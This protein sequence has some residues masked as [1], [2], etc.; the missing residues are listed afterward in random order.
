VPVLVTLLDT[1]DPQIR[2]GLGQVAALLEREQTVQALRSV[3]RSR[4][5][6]DNARLTAM[7]ILDRYLHEPVDESLLAGLQDPEAVASQSLRELSHE[8][9]NNPFIVLEYLNQLG[10]QPAEVAGVVLDAIPRLRPDPHLV[11][12]LRMFAQGGDTALAQRALD[13][14]SRIRAPEAGRALLSLTGALPSSLAA[15]ADRGLR[16]LRLLGIAEQAPAG[17]KQW[18]AFLSP[19]DGTGAQ[20]IWFTSHAGD[21][22]HGTL[23]SILCRDPDGIVAS[24]GSSEVAV[25]DLPPSNEQGAAFV[26]R[27]AEDALPITLL[28]VPV[29]AARHAVRAAQEL[30]WARDTLPPPEYRL[31]NNQIW[32]LGPLSPADEPA[33]GDYTPEQTAALLDHPAFISWFWQAAA[34]Y[35]AAGQLGRR[36]ALAERVAV[37]KT[38]LESHFGSELVASY[39]RRLAS[40]ARWLALAGQPEAAALAQA[41]STHLA[42]VPPAQVPFFQRLA[43]IGLD[44]AVAYLRSGF[45][46]RRH[47]GD[48]A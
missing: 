6:N 35:E 31:L 48:S 38:L 1:T 5:R 32:E 23:F 42:D 11:T 18:H 2:G 12:L 15:S 43:G 21:A 3:A 7:M 10:E 22:G 47:L 28:A 25:E 36:P 26:I 13:Q 24:F 30:N 16:K 41:A 8:M 9:G 45:D 17:T 40:M 27:Q 19:V 37:V 44:V 4:E 46:W 20:V 39:R 14:L 29:D 34:V 33:P